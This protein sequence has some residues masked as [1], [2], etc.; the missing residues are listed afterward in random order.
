MSLNGAPQPGA[1]AEERPA[2]FTAY[3]ES[4]YIKREEVQAVALE[5]VLNECDDISEVFK[6]NI[7]AAYRSEAQLEAARQ[8]DR[9]ALNQ[10]LLCTPVL[11]TAPYVQFP[12][13]A[14]GAEQVK[15]CSKINDSLTPLDFSSR[16][17]KHWLQHFDVLFN[18]KFIPERIVRL[19]IVY[20][21]CSLPL[22]QQIL[23]M[24]VCSRAEREDFKFQDFLQIL[25]VL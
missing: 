6:N 2:W 20:N 16:S 1:E 10:Q 7:R 19:A 9:E 14:I 17:L 22:Q 25:C 21:S 3:L 13:S 24:N 12:W 23:S 15:V 8:T 5:N 4:L 18:K 11:Y